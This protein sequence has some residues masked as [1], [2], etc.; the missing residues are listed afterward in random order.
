MPAFAIASEVTVQD[1]DLTAAGAALLE[2]MIAGEWKS[3]QLPARYVRKLDARKGAMQRWL[4]QAR[5]RD[6]G[7]E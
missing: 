2:I 5:R 6:A 4:Q 1:Q 7:E 3:P